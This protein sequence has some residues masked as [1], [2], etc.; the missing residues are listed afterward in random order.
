MSKRS[1]RLVAIVGLVLAIGNCPHK[2]GA[3]KVKGFVDYLD[4]KCDGGK[5]LLETTAG[6]K[7]ECYQFCKDKKKCKAAQYNKGN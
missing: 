4:V 5:E 1:F 6:N 7:D 3:T 2:A